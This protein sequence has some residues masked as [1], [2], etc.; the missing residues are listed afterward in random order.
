MKTFNGL[1]DM[2]KDDLLAALGLETRRS[3]IGHW[4]GGIALGLMVGAGLVFLLSPKTGRDVLANLKDRL[5]D[6]KIPV[7]GADHGPQPTQPSAVS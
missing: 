2:D 4:M 7:P 6:L 5:Q 1:K 3:R